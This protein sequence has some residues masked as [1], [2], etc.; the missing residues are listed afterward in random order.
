M[1]DMSDRLTL[2]QSRFTPGETYNAEQIR[3]AFVVHFAERIDGVIDLAYL[4]ANGRLHFEVEKEELSEI[5]LDVPNKLGCDVY[6]VLPEVF[7][8][9]V[10]EN[11]SSGLT[12]FQGVNTNGRLAYRCVGYEPKKRVILGEPICKKWC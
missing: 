5:V 9:A 1:G 11:C 12:I 8:I 3:H 6:D 4:F 10:A 2:F 7:Q